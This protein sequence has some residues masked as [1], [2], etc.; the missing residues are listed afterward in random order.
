MEEEKTIM[1]DI[2]EKVED[3]MTELVKNEGV[4]RDNAEYLYQLVDIH[5]DIKNEKYWE[6]KEEKYD[7]EIQRR[8]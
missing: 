1:D 2:L 4:R 8:L 7:D 3:K 5:K 6:K